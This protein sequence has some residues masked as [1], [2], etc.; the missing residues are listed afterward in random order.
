MQSSSITLSCEWPRLN[1]KNKQ[2]DKCGAGTVVVFSIEKGF[3]FTALCDS[4]TESAMSMIQ[5]A[6]GKQCVGTAFLLVQP[7]SAG[8]YTFL[9]LQQLLGYNVT[10]ILALTPQQTLCTVKSGVDLASEWQLK[11]L[12]LQTA[13]LAEFLQKPSSHQELIP[14]EKSRPA[15]MYH[16]VM[17]P[18]MTSLF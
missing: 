15:T 4:V 17:Q 11:Y 5:R 7:S 3:A 13:R 14:P 2:W 12:C 18:S 8:G 9:W 16:K 10:V 1:R 6:T